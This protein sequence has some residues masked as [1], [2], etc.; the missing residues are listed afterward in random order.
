[1]LRRNC[2]S[3]DSRLFGGFDDPA[4]LQCD[5]PGAVVPGLSAALDDV[6][7]QFGFGEFSSDPGVVVAAVEMDRLEVGDTTVGCDRVQGGGASMRT[8]SGVGARR[9]FTSDSAAASAG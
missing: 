3:F 1:M 6:I 2:P 7:G 8:P 5:R 9:N 4:Q